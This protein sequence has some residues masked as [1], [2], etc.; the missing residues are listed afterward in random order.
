MELEVLAM[1]AEKM[2][3]PVQQTRKRA[4]EVLSLFPPAI[5]APYKDIPCLPA[6]YTLVQQQVQD[7]TKYKNREP[8]FLD[9]R[10]LF[11]RFDGPPFNEQD[12]KQIVRNEAVVGWTAANVF[13]RFKLSDLD[14]RQLRAYYDACS[15]C[16]YRDW[17]AST[18]R[19]R[20]VHALGATDTAAAVDMLLAALK[21]D[22]Y[23]WARIG[24]ARSLVEIAA[25]TADADLRSK[26]IDTLIDTVREAG[27]ETLALKMLH[28]IGHSAFYCDAHAGWEQAVTPLIIKVRDR[29]NDN[30]PE[31]GW[32]SNL[33][34]DFEK[35]CR[36]QAPLAAEAVGASTVIALH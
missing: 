17:R 5:A 35:F 21:E 19:S 11:V 33:L 2:F 25:L 15:A 1:V 26:V 14:V 23:L 7:E 4:N 36:E 22:H 6:L 34:A 13:R 8:W 24:A 31:K 16:D 10:N 28:E 12:L 9:W 3:D 32:W 27:S 29:Q 30:D 18:I 20:V